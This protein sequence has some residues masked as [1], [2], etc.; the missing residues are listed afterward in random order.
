MEVLCL[1]FINTEWYSKHDGADECLYN[2][3]WIKNFCDKWDIKQPCFCDQSCE[4]LIKF[5]SELFQIM[6]QLSTEKKL[7]S[8]NI[9][10]LNKYL[11]KGKS[12]QSI[13][14]ENSTFK[15]NV[16]PEID[17]LEWMI[18]KI[19]LSC[20]NLLTTKPLEYLKKCANPDC[21]WIF[22]DDSKNH[23]R[24]WCDNKCAS[25]MK[26]RKYREN[27]KNKAE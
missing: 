13:S 12:K 20:A 25:L 26:V 24:K 2:F 5:R 6:L 22:Y 4:K 21:D 18:Y 19:S 11:K 8:A 7:S 16:I 27:K 1:E 3:E 15:L 10:K 23:S 14:Y 17:D 9:K